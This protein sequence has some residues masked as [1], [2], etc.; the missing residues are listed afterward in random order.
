MNLST[1]TNMPDPNAHPDDMLSPAKPNDMPPL[2]WLSPWTYAIQ[3]KSA[4]DLLHDMADDSAAQIHGLQTAVIAKD[5]EMVQHR[6]RLNDF[7]RKVELRLSS[8]KDA[9]A[10]EDTY[11][12]VDWAADR[13]DILGRGMNA[14]ADEVERLKKERDALREDRNRLADELAEKNSLLRA[15][16]AVKEG[17]RRAHEAEMGRAVYWELQAKDARKERDDARARA[18][19][20]AG[21]KAKPAMARSAKGRSRR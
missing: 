8:V 3:L 5:G 16:E 1:R 7:Q 10:Y 13:I 19:G 20:K 14:L 4:V 21:R 6:K 2:W 9:P 11:D 18:R 12:L 17:H 15:S